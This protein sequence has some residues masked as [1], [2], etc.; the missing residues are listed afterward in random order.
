MLIALMLFITKGL[1]FWIYRIPNK[2]AQNVVVGA[3]VLL[4]IICVISAFAAT[5]LPSLPNN[6]L[7][8]SDLLI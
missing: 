8:P 2:L 7:I 6:V 5:Y 1:A 4:L 3:V